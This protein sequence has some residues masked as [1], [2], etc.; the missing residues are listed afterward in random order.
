MTPK[1]KCFECGCPLKI[2][3]MVES[4]IVTCPECGFEF[5]VKQ[6]NDHL[7]LQVLTFEGED[8]GE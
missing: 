7:E 2:K 8:W 3:D 4:E 1:M 5:E 6:V